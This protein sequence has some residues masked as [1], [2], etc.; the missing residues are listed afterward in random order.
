MTGANKTEIRFQGAEISKTALHKATLISR[1]TKDGWNVVEDDV[2]LGKVYWV[3]LESIATLK[4]GQHWRP[5]I[6]VDREC[7]LAYDTPKGG[8]GGYMILELLKIEANA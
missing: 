7:I 8:G 3:D 5:G 2:P 1:Y 6:E 4:H